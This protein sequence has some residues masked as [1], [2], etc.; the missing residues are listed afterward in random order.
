MPDFPVVAKA[1]FFIEGDET[2]GPQQGCVVQHEEALWLVA[3]WLESN[4]TGKRYPAQLVPMER[5]PYQMKEI[6]SFRLRSA[7]PK[8]L[9]SY[10]IQP[11]LRLAYGVVD[12]SALAHIPGP[13][14]SH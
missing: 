11:T 2:L 9:L 4:T 13:A 8:A 14:S 1:I 6:G 7:I 3:N 12:V 10:P 5:L